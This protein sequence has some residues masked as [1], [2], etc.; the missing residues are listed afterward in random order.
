MHSF[1]PSWSQVTLL[2]QLP[3]Y[4]GRK[5]HATTPGLTTPFKCLSKIICLLY[6][7][8]RSSH[9][10]SWWDHDIHFMYCNIIETTEV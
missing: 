9:K 1:C 8:S 3:E 7:N 5:A 6:V 4:L 10:V 2:P